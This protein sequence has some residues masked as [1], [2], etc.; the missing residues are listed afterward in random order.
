[1]ITRQQ[2]EDMVARLTG[3][4]EFGPQCGSATKKAID[5]VLLREAVDLLTDM[6]AELWGDG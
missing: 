6:M 1:M 4:L 2:A 5:G 3:V